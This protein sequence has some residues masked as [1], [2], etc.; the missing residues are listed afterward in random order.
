[1]ITGKTGLFFS[2]QSVGSIC[3][4]VKRFEGVRDDFNP[5]I[6][7]K[8]A[9]RFSRERFEREF[10]SFVEGKLAECYSSLSFRADSSFLAEGEGISI[11]AQVNGEIVEK[12]ITV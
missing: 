3:E 7:S 11:S 9:G 5:E 1:M 8:N 4:A 10:K 6:I 12:D 2:E